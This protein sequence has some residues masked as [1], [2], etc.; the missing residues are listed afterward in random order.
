MLNKESI[1][2][3]IREEGYS[4]AEALCIYNDMKLNYLEGEDE[5]DEVIDEITASAEEWVENNQ[6]LA[7]MGFNI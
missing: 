3:I 5:T 1:L 6:D 2:N 7:N 4:S